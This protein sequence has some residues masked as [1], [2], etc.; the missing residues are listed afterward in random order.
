MKALIGI[1]ELRLKGNTGQFFKGIDFLSTFPTT[2][3]KAH[4]STN[5]LDMMEDPYSEDGNWR[6]P[7][8]L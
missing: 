3:S 5:L 6:H 2:L 7:K 8:R 4:A 1:L